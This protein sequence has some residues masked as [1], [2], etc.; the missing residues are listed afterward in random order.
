MRK[1]IKETSEFIVL[2]LAKKLLENGHIVFGFDVMNDYYEVNIKKT[3]IK[4]F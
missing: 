2:H 1:I 4:F 3:E